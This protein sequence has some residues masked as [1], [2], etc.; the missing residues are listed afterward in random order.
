MVLRGDTKTSLWELHARTEAHS[1]QLR[2]ICPLNENIVKKND[3]VNSEDSILIVAS[4]TCNKGGKTVVYKI[5]VLIISRGRIIRTAGYRASDLTFKGRC[6]ENIFIYTAEGANN[7]FV[8]PLDKIS[9][10]QCGRSYAS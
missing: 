6:K 4:S 3:L 8:A 10:P 7:P 1:I 9:Q 2:K 5:S